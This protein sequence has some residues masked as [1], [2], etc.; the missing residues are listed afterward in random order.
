[1]GSEKC[2]P[3]FKRYWKHMVQK[4]SSNPVIHNLNI[5]SNNKLSNIFV[6]SIKTLIGMVVKITVIA[7]AFVMKFTGLA[8]T[9]TAETIEKLIVKRTTL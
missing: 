9:K 2:L 8:L 6:S 4:L 7:L 5:M 3:S 1:M